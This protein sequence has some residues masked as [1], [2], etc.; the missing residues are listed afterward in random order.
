[1]VM[2]AWPVQEPPVYC[3]QCQRVYPIA[4]HR[5]V[6]MMGFISHQNAV[7]HG[8]NRGNTVMQTSSKALGF[9]QTCDHL[10]STSECKPTPEHRTIL[11]TCIAVCW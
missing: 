2:A 10:P 8:S 3:S 9:S 7:C 6:S 4:E 1:M 11:H 5:N